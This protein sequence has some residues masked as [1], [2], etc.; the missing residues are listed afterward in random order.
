MDLLRQLIDWSGGCGDGRRDL[1]SPE[2]VA[3]VPQIKHKRCDLSQ[4]MTIE[5][6]EIAYEFSL[7]AGFEAAFSNINL[8]MPGTGAGGVDRV[9]P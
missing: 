2:S 4:Y 9:S 3:P 8:G 1:I 7:K 5:K 6:S